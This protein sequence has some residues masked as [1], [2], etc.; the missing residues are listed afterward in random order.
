MFPHQLVYAS[1]PPVRF[2]VVNESMV[3]CRNLIFQHHLPEKSFEN[4]EI[5]SVGS[6]LFDGPVQSFTHDE[7]LNCTKQF[8]N[9]KSWKQLF[10]GIIDIN[11]TASLL[12]ILRTHTNK[13]TH[14]LINCT[15]RCFQ[16]EKRNQQFF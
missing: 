8:N 13:L 5:E 1:F 15:G 3:L 7:S 6:R 2:F 9:S 12:E 10:G 4:V 14:H 16:A 11:N